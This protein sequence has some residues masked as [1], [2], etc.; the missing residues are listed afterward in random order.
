MENGHRPEG[1][2]LAERGVG[3][4]RYEWASYG[5]SV[6][7]EQVRETRYGMTAEILVE[8]VA[9]HPETGRRGHLHFGQLNLSKAPEKALLEALVRRDERVPWVD[10]LEVVRVQTA[11]DMRAGEPTLVL[12]DVPTAQYR[13]LIDRMIPAGET[14]VV[15]GDGASGKSLIGGIV[16]AL[17]VATGKPIGPIRPC[18]QAPVLV[19]DW[20]T[21]PA[22][23]SERLERVAM[24]ARLPVPA[25]IEYRSQWRPL[26]D[27]LERIRT[28]VARLNAGLVLVDS[29]ALAVGGEVTADTCVPFYNALR[30]LGETT[31]VVLSHVSK[32]TAQLET[33]VG[34]PYGSIFVKNFARSAWGIR[35]DDI[36]LPGG[37]FETVLT[38]RKVNRGRLQGSIGLRVGFE[39][40]DGPI[41][42]TPL[43]ALA[44]PG[45]AVHASLA[46][47][48]RAVLRRGAMST[49]QL[50]EELGKPE[51]AVRATASR[52]VARGIVVRL[53]A[54]GGRG[55]ATRYG[56]ADPHGNEQQQEPETATAWFEESR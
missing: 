55:N 31:R 52:L 2:R 18:I 42:L 35:R 4:Y 12:R 10:L 32:S 22:E 44:T 36:E 48:L 17:A 30:S 38:H 46:D 41:T 43:D 56:L 1:F 13:D 9:T 24:G 47:Q 14:S 21:T 33:G 50:A 28:D 16:L 49:T 23:W 19:L 3:R 5:Y 51:N 7:L 8:T 6:L 25:T 15:F 20:E 29:I 37:G 45:L 34:D 54:G 11:R 53:D 39:D 40:P 26:V 27:D